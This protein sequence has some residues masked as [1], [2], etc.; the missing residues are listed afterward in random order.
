MKK[1]RSRRVISGPAGLVHFEVVSEDDPR[2]AEQIA[3]LATLVPGVAHYVKGI[4]Y[5]LL[6]VRSLYC[7][8][9]SDG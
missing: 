3:V 4:G 7:I 6:G 2:Y 8:E 9:V 5:R 1:P